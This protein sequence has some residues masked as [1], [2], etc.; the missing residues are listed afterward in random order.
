MGYIPAGGDLV[1]AEAVSSL[2]ACGYV[3]LFGYEKVLLWRHNSLQLQRGVKELGQA[4]RLKL[5]LRQV[6]NIFFIVRH[7]ELD[8]DAHLQIA[9]D[10]GKPG[11]V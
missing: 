1:L 6:H 3:C 10:S 11:Q 4:V 5:L 2:A 9:V 8:R 7:P